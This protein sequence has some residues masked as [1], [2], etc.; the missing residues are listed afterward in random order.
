[1][2]LTVDSIILVSVNGTVFLF[3]FFQ[4]GA[5][6]KAKTQL[7]HTVNGPKYTAVDC[8]HVHSKPKMAH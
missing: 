8:S 6:F 4:S 3:I 5:R 2:N 7:K 1:M